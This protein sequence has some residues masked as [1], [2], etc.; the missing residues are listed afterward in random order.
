MSAAFNLPATGGTHGHRT[1]AVCPCA[2]GSVC[3]FAHSPAYK[4][5]HVDAKGRRHQLVLECAGRAAAEA[6]AVAM[7]GL[8]L[9]LAAIRLQ[10]GAA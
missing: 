4:V 9:Y 1:A 8:P 6:L 2:Q 10:G 3:A 7:Y 5:T